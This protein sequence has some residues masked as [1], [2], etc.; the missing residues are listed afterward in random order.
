M[1]KLRNKI[2]RMEASHLFLFSMHL[3]DMQPTV[4]APV[5]PVSRK[6]SLHG[7]TIS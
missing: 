1:L 4:I 5:E 6:L 3:F 7:H 2:P